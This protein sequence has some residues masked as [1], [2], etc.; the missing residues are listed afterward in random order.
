M[1]FADG[2]LRER[3]DRTYRYNDY[4]IWAFPNLEPDIDYS[5]IVQDGNN[6]SACFVKGQN[7]FFSDDPSQALGYADSYLTNYLILRAQQYALPGLL[8]QF[9]LS[10]TQLAVSTASD[11]LSNTTFPTLR[12]PDIDLELLI[13]PLT[14]LPFSIRSYEN[15][16]VFGLS[17]SD[18]TFA[19][20]TQ[21]IVDD[22]HSVLLPRRFIT[23]YNSKYSLEDFIVDE[24]VI[25]PVF[26]SDYFDAD[27]FR[28]LNISASASL[29]PSP[30]SESAEYPLSEVHE[31]F[32]A[33]LWSGPFTE[34]FNTSDVI[35][36]PV[37]PN[38]TVPQ[39]M[40]LFVGYP[41]YVQLLIEFADGL[42][43][44]DAPAHRSKIILEW[45]SSTQ[46]FSGKQVKWVVPSHHHRDHAGGVGDYIAAG[47]TLIIPKIA[48]TFYQQASSAQFPVVTYTEGAPFHHSDGIVQLSSFWAKDNPHAEDWSYSV[49]S[50][51]CSQDGSEFVI[52]NADVVSPGPGEALRW[53]VG[54]ARQW[55]F[56][57][58]SDGIPKDAVVV[59]AHGSSE[60]GLGT[61]DTLA[62]I[63]DLSGVRY[64]ENMFKASQAWC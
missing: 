8:K 20:W 28:S 34:Q 43:I 4:W 59:G 61:Q 23:V 36:A 41:D 16:T 25:N 5:L 57:A 14:N 39:I 32:E 64:P 21:T 63:A 51:A 10:E 1:S 31:F 17:T 42:L 7:S 18:L 37:F 3:I 33:G 50:P 54:S 45:L 35:V 55:M 9:A 38:G 29:Q 24:I 13:D 44:T 27:E 53:D 46:M 30:P 2:A 12:H 6:A 26:P 56:A 48:E 11:R 15:H 47:A 40:N 22:E 52:F 49:A 60:I 62:N 19:N 58:A